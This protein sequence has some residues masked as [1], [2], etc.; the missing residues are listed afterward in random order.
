MKRSMIR[1]STYREIRG[2]L[3]RFLA[4]LA[5]VALGVGLFAGLK[6]TKADFLKS[7]S[8]YFQETSFYDYRILGGLGFSEEQVKYF[9]SLDGVEAAEGALYADML[10]DEEGAS[11]RVGRFHSI[12]EDVNRVVLTAGRMPEK[13]GECLADSKVFSESAIGTTI[14]FSP[15]NGPDS[16]DQFQ[17]DA[18]EIVGLAKSPLYIQY[19]RGN[20]SLGSGTIDAFF[21]LPKESFSADYFAEIYVRFGEDFDL[22]SDEY[23]D[24]I[25]E[26]E[27]LFEDAVQEACRMRF[28]ELPGLIA[29][30]EETLAR[31]KEDAWKELEEAREE[32]EDA[33]AELDQAD[34][35]IRD[36]RRQLSEGREETARAELDLSEAKETVAEKKAQLEQGILDLEA[37]QK[38]IE[39]NE[40]TLS[41]KEA[42]LEQAKS[43]LSASE[44]TLQ[45][46]EMQQKLTMEGLISEQK[47]IDSSQAELDRRSASADALEATAEQLGLGD[48]Y[49]QRIA[50]ER[51]EIAGEQAKL[52]LQ[53]TDL[54]NRY[55]EALKTGDQIQSGR[56]ELE[57][58]RKEVQEGETALQEGK[59]KLLQGKEELLAA[60]RE[61]EDGRTAIREAEQEIRQGEK[62]LEEGKKTLEEKEAELEDGVREYQEG[63]EAYQEGLAEYNDGL[64]EYEEK[65]ADAEEAIQKQKDQLEEGTVPE[66]YLLG[67]NTNIGYVC[68]ENDS[69]IVDGI[70]NVFPVFFFLVAA[71]VCITTMNRMVEEQRTQ[72]GVLKAL[73]YSDGAIMSKYIFYSGLAAVS[74]CAVGYAG[75]THVFPFIIWTVYGIM[76]QAGPIAF[77]FSPGLALLSLAVS[78]LCSVGATYLSCGKELGG[79][80]AELMRPKAPKA[81]KRVFLEYV[82]FVWKRLSFLRK[83]AVRNI[84]RYKKRLFMMVLGIGGCTGLLLTG[85][86]IK[87]SI[88]DVGGMQYGEIHRY[89]VSVLLQDEFDGAFQE[90]LE[91]LSEK[92]LED[93]L[94]LQE[95]TQDLSDGEKQKSVTAVVL[96]EGISDEELREFIDLHTPE[97]EPIAPPGPGEAVLTD[98]MAEEFGVSEGDTIL[99]LDSDRKEMRLTVSGIARNYIYN[100]VYLGQGTWEK[101]K[102]EKFAPKTVYLN[103][104]D[105]FEPSGL[106]AAVMDLEGVASLSVT[107]DMLERFDRMMSSLNLIVVVVIFC[108]AGLAFIVLYNLTNINI[109]ER[110]REIATIKVL[111][112]FSGETALYVFRENMVL[113]F[114]GALAGLGMGKWLHAF[115]MRE[116]NVDM[117][118][119]DVRI[120]PVSYLYSVLLT[121]VFALG[122]NLLMNRKL[123]NINMTES[124]KSVD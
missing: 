20:T 37:G 111:G 97:G 64:R 4:I 120:L 55:L 69:A 82:P 109:T 75:G 68:F 46:G 15:E 83:V 29:D 108:A 62:D 12:T 21:Y 63:L 103:L 32:L 124:L 77:V 41:E 91:A 1:R 60:K 117:V 48:A 99:L 57:K 102:G 45:L 96:P 121:F 90:A 24:F 73:G 3:G 13:A 26:K 71:L 16:L 84:M 58:S 122:V 22:Y 70:A 54:H 67:R 5:I 40:K 44:M 36:G 2:S 51:E 98:K 106:S 30:A 35:T 43:L 53:L 100:Y 95:S 72:I 65:I 25:E 9:A 94:P 80:A 112:F 52:D 87:D 34:E 8:R 107:R 76:Y 66:G 23:A 86:G 116:I 27:T 104:A 50:K 118:S 74:G 10:F 6:I 33:K 115:V 114:L 110:I 47:S 61:I 7:M 42:E 79:W 88:A 89:D 113:T 19:E 56:A 101:E 119:F 81:G 59:E 18:Y 38:E 39:E 28:E 123:E 105:G 17:E 49:A 85:F 78:L 14:T 31:E 93:F 92:G 11:G